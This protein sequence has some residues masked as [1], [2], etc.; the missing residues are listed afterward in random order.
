MST[1]TTAVRAHL[2]ESLDNDGCPFC[3]VGSLEQ[4]TYEGDP[5]VL[6]DHCGVPVVRLSG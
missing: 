1:T 6:C 2:F 4:G 3:E 5:A